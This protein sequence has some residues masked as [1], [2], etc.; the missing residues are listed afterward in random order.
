MPVYRDNRS[1][2]ARLHESKLDLFVQEA[3]VEIC[4]PAHR[5]PGSV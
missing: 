1:D 4:K 2:T 3:G 5:R